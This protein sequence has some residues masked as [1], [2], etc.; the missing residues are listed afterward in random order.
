MLRIGSS[1]VR[2]RQGWTCLLHFKRIETC[3]RRPPWP[4]SCRGL[5]GPVSSIL[6]GLKPPGVY[7]ATRL[8]TECWTCLLHFKRIETRAQCTHP[9]RTHHP[10]WTCLLHF[11]RIET[12]AGVTPDLL[13]PHV[14][15]PV[16]SILRGLKRNVPAAVV[17]PYLQVLDLSSPF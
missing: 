2:C 16:S 15:G 5:V 17:R 9:Q 10:R 12:A 1:P 4:Q 3:L 14:V 6:R 7:R 13:L 8:R 11:K